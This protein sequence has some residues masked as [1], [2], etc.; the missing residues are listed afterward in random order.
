MFTLSWI[1]IKSAIVY[2]ILMA[3]LSMIVYVISVHDLWA[4]DTHVLINSGVLAFFTGI[5]S[6][7]KN[8]LTTDSGKFLGIFQVVPPTK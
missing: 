8:I 5:T 7:I 6:L 2:A 3:L 4:I 1:N